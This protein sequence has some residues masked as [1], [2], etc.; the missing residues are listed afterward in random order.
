MP[1]LSITCLVV[2]VNDPDHVEPGSTGM[3]KHPALAVIKRAKCSVAER[4]HQRHDRG[5]VDDPANA[6]GADGVK[7]VVDPAKWVG[8]TDGG[9]IWRRHLCRSG[10]DA[11]QFIEQ[12]SVCVMDRQHGKGQR[13]SGW[14][15]P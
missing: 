12:K 8:K 15:T 6:C 4:G 13:I 10:R 11:R 5:Q 2:M 7:H 14:K 1:N 9:E 3:V